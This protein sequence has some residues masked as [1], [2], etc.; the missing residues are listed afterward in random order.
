MRLKFGWSPLLLLL[1]LAHFQLIAS[2]TLILHR[3]FSSERIRYP[4]L[5]IEEEMTLDIDKLQTTR[6]EQYTEE[7]IPNLGLLPHKVWMKFSIKNESGV[8]QVLIRY[9]YSLF[10][11]VEFVVYNSEGA[12]IEAKTFTKTGSKEHLLYR[13]S[14][15]IINLSI[16]P[17]EIVTV[18]VSLTN[19]EQTLLPVYV[20]TDRELTSDIAKQNL[21]LG[22]FG[23]IVLIMF[24]YNFFVY[25]STRDRNYLYY[26]VYIL[27][28]GLTQL[29]IAGVTSLYLWPN[30]DWMI[31]RSST[32]LPSVAGIFSLI[33]SASFL[34]LVHLSKRLLMFAYLPLI[35]SFLISLILSTLGLL[36]PS[37]VIMQATTMVTAIIILLSAIL[38]YREGFYSARFFVLAW[39]ILLLGAFVFILKDYGVLPYN[40]FTNSAV[41]M[42]ASIELALLSFAL[43]DKINEFKREN[44]LA[45]IERLELERKNSQIM[46]EQNVILEQKVAERTLKLNEMNDE[47][48][49]AYDSLKSA[50]TNL[51]SSEKMV[52]L[53]QLT[54]GIAHEINNPINFVSAN[55]GPLRRDVSDL[56]ELFEKTEEALN[57]E[58]SEDAR[59]KINDLKEELEYDYIKNEIEELLRGMTDGTNRTV[60]IVRGLKTFS[61]V[62]ENDQK[63][64]D[65]HEG[66]DSTLVLLNNSLKDS[67]VV[68]KEYGQISKVECFPGKINQVFMNIINNAGQALKKFNSGERGIIKIKTWQS[69]GVVCISIKDNGPGI[70]REII[71]KIFDPF[72]TTKPVG[73]GTGLGLSIVYNIIKSHSGKIDVI[74]EPGQGAEFRIILPIASPKKNEQREREE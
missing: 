73:E 71:E 42:G 37:F 23:G 55:I 46:R 61:R 49:K 20:S 22:I 67:V 29:S 5:F 70:P 14:N 24:V 18:F 8:E 35:A 72:F 1:I 57:T 47:L 45:N 25:L 74:S 15:P 66:I 62:D 65:L 19:L 10:D 32:F 31:I 50:Q 53:G 28:I 4:D 43:A 51:V 69:D 21:I 12:L 16:P 59:Q 38:V 40:L 56:I 52:S 34:N 36:Q 68:E 39:S 3:D 7:E 30:W 63:I 60:E 33:F 6:F 64:V 13:H 48:V 26:I 11:S 58:N 17:G 27:F 44:E 2:D 54:A 9:S 41:Q